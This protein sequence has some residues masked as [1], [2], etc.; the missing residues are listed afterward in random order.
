MPR[1][2]A[3]ERKLSRQTDPRRLL[4]RTLATQLVEHHS[5]T[6]TWPRAKR[7]VPYI[8]RLTA[9][10]KKGDLTARR[11]VR[12]RLDTVEA[13]HHLIDVIAPQTKRDSGFVRQVRAGFRS[14][15]RAP[16]ATVSFVDEISEVTAPKSAPVK[17]S[18]PAKKPLA[19]KDKPKS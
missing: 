10:A 1:L 5:I 7:L 2:R 6:T 3:S 11:Y 12:A 9:R 13:T 19:K 15:D 4:I 16:L 14:G 18:Q 8:D 17:S